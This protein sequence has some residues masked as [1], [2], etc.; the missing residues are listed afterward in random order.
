V[1]TARI[2]DGTPRPRLLDLFCGAGGA[3]MGYWRAG[4]EVVGVD[5]Q[6]QPRY[7]F[8]FHQA[9]A[10]T[11]PLDG[12]D[13]YHGS[14]P[15]ER[16]SRATKTQQRDN[17]PDL[18]A[19][20]RQR[21]LATGKP[22]VLENV[23]RAPL[24]PD[25]KLCGCVAG[26]PELERER[27]F[28][29]WPQLFDLR[30]GCYHTAPIVSVTGHGRCRTMAPGTGLVVDWRRVMGIDWMTRDELRKAIPPAYTVIVGELLMAAM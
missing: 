9:D 6:P 17:Y 15:C 19:P 12:F 27:W 8:E 25:L 20:T 4:W 5:N 16:Y 21:L 29:T 7:P 3:G 30:P 24:R 14:P 22:F 28:E 26:L 10:M 23:P 18:L 1:S 13:A 11:F 2:P